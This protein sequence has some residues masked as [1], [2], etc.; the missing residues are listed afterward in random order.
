MTVPGGYAFRP[1]TEAD[2]GLIAGWLAEP[3]V[4]AWWG[5]DAAYDAD[6]LAD[7]RVARRIV[8]LAGRPFAYMQDYAVHGWPDHHFAALPAG[9]RGIDQFIGPPDMLGL[10]HGPAFVADRLR[11]LF[12]EGAPVVATDPHPDNARAI[13]AYRRCGFAASGP[14]VETRWG[15]VLPMIARPG[16]VPCRPAVAVRPRPAAPQ[17]RS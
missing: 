17:P 14:P 5:E 8:S 6:D 1:V 2:L 13:A 15:R 16:A 11:A 4:R 9:S 10:G 12:A 7:R 3:H